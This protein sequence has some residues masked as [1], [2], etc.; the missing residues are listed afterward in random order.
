[1]LV[2]T[3]GWGQAA[4]QLTSAYKQM[5]GEFE[6]TVLLAQEAEVFWSLNALV[7]LL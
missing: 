2:G 4:L 3:V 6:S 7:C 1:M 5:A